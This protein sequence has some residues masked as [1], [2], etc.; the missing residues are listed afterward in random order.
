MKQKS[1]KIESGS[2][3]AIVGGGPAGSFFALYLTHYARQNGINLDITIY[4]KRNFDELGPKGCKGCAGILSASL[5]KNLD[6]LDSRVPQEII[7]SNIAR[8]IVHSPYTS[9]SLSKP[10][11][12]MEVASVYRGGGPRL[13]NYMR[14]I[15]LDSWLLTQA[16]GKGA[17]S[18]NQAASKI[19]LEGVPIVEVAGKKVEYDL[20]VLATGV[21]SKPIPI[22]GLPYVS[23]RTRIMSQAELYVGMDKVRSHLGDMAHVFLMP[24]SN[25]IFGALVPKGPFINALVL[26]SGK[27]PISVADFMQLD[28]VRN[29]LPENYERACECRPRAV[30]SPAHNYYSD[31]FVA[32]GDAAVSRLYKDGIGS[33]LLTARAAAGTVVFHGVSRQDF[34][35]HYQPLCRALYWDNHWGK[36]LFSIH[37]RSKDCRAFLL[38]QHRLI[39]DEQ[40]NTTGAQPFTKITWG[41]FTGSYSYGSMT[42]MAFAPGSL[43]KLCRAFFE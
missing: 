13:F 43:W 22:V 16:Q 21:N 24:H 33:S 32:I 10:Q 37:S 20:V 2:R 23:P 34:E 42:R 35:R 8:Y 39:G 31:R 9:I 15:S 38:A 3:I 29:I 17:K 19:H 14:G 11:N 25:M 41:M 18:E 28:I 7:Q 36:L 40:S 26:S 27:N 1:S 12:E 6:E 30:I 5:L 4:E